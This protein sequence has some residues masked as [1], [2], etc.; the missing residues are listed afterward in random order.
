MRSTQAFAVMFLC[1][2]GTNCAAGGL[3]VFSGHGFGSTLYRLE[4]TFPITGMD[5]IPG[6]SS[7]LGQSELEYPLDAWLAGVRWMGGSQKV[8]WRASAWT[9]FSDP[10]NRMLDT[11]WFGSRNSQGS[12][13]ASML[14]KFSYTR[15]QAEM[16]W[17][18]GEAGLDFGDFEL[19][20]KPMRYGLSLR[21]ERIAFRMFGIEGWQRIPDEPR[22]NVG[23]S[24]D[25]LV[26]TYSLVRARPR[27]TAE[28]LLAGGKGVS[29][30]GTA[31][32]GP[33][34]AWDHDDHVLRN[35]ESNA[36]AFGFEIGGGAGLEIRL[37]PDLALTL[38][39]EMAYLRAKGE[40][41]QRYYG[42]DPGS[43]GEDETGLERKGITNRII[44]IGGGVDLG[45][46]W[47]F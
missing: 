9:N 21:A 24:A 35:K 5:S 23:M 16:R 15:S 36:F 39:A 2:L 42:D 28:M 12:A 20:G 22:V 1:A 45:V 41:E 43:S 30:R 33:Y 44:G 34:L 10:G 6:A 14:Y 40:M 47:L 46:R 4:I 18:G 17:F 8:G 11:D 13:S 26:L 37:S 25:S 32:A 27:L 38:A 31:A 3:E 19:L 29:L 7:G